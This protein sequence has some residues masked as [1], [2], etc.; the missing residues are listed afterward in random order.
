MFELLSAFFIFWNYVEDSKKI[1]KLWKVLCKYGSFLKWYYKNPE[2]KIKYSSI[3]RVGLD[4]KIID[5]IYENLIDNKKRF[6]DGFTKEKDSLLFELENSKLGYRILVDPVNESTQN[7]CLETKF[8]PFYPLR[9][10]KK[11]DII[12]AEFNEIFKIISNPLKI[13][14]DSKIIFVEIE[15]LNDNKSKKVY[16]KSNAKISFKGNKIQI[17]D[18]HGTEHGNLLFYFVMKWLTEYRIKSTSPM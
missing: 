8:I 18:Y 17:N 10:F 2:V 14:Q 16:E 4:N 13:I 1:F 3:V 11:L 9:K 12:T 15:E 7:I 5:K 6:L